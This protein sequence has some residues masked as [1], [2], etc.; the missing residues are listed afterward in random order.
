M[1]KEIT[2]AQVGTFGEKYCAK[3]LKRNR[4]KIYE[5]NAKIGHLET[6]IIAY[7]K[8]FLLFVEVKTRRT[9]K[10]NYGTPASAVDYKKR[11]NLLKFAFA[12]CSYLPNKLKDKNIRLDVCEIWVTGDKKLKVCDFNYI[13]NAI[14][15]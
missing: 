3:Y 8:D 10:V 13:E 6:D 12:F 5:M 7:N 1:I 14:M 9:N 4:F 15:G 11:T 2:K